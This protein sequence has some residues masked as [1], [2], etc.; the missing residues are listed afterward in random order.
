M[1]SIGMRK[2]SHGRGRMQTE[3]EDP[4]GAPGDSPDQHAVTNRKR[5]GDR[6]EAEYQGRRLA[7]HRKLISHRIFHFV[8]G[9]RSAPEPQEFMTLVGLMAAI[10]R[11]WARPP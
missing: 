4:A 7:K 2:T 6:D 3:G 10:V 5:C 1:N 9:V 11:R 8:I